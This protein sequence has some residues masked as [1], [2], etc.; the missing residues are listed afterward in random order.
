MKISS[1]YRYGEWAKEVLG[2]E[3]IQ[4][5]LENNEISVTSIFV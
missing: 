2:G 3:D 4:W 5:D 1:G